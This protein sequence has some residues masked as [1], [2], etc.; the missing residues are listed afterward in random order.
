MNRTVS[1][2]L[3]ALVLAGGL[4]AVACGSDGGGIT[5]GGGGSS[6][7]G[8]EKDPANAAKAYLLT[9]IRVFTGETKAED[10]MRLFEES[11]RSSVSAADVQKGLERE[12]NEYPK[13]KGV[14]LQDFDFQGKAKVEKT[15]D[16]ATVT[17]PPVDE[18]RVKIDGKWLNAFEYFKGVGLADDSDKG[19]P[20]DVDLIL[21]N[22]RYYQADCEDLED[23]AAAG[24][25]ANA[26]PTPQRNTPTP[27]RGTPTATNRTPTPRPA[28]TTTSA[29]P[30][31]TTTPATIGR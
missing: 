8:G 19:D 5:G 30:P 25:R 3:R 15:G 16:E 10:M 13:L 26:T 17:V 18:I 24:R 29:T 11:C 20:T 23:I 1:H 14:K 9:V 21:R 22:G 6:S 2:L 4:L 27:Q 28:G 31:R 12:Q 7:G